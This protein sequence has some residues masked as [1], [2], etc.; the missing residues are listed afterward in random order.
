[1]TN[2]DLPS[3][4]QRALEMRESE[5]EG[6][7]LANASGQEGFNEE[8]DNLIYSY[9]EGNEQKKKKKRI[10]ENAIYMPMIN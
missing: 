1:M 6:L 7:L 4:V 2:G 10:L 9:R 8:I 3:L 5:K